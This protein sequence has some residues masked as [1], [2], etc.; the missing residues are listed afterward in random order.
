MQPQA[1]PSPDRPEG[2]R[3][4]VTRGEGQPEQVVELRDVAEPLARVPVV[5][6][7]DRPNDV[8]EP[9]R[10]RHRQQGQAKLPRPHG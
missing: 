7:G 1:K 10:V 2:G 8:A 5:G 6:P 9:D 3:P 4:E